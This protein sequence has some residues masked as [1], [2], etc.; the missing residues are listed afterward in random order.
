MIT[1]ENNPGCRGPNATSRANKIASWTKSLQN[2]KSIEND[3]RSHLLY[4]QVLLSI[5]I[6][7]VSSHFTP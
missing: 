2:T 4:G 1:A 6:N 7:N 3:V 5:L